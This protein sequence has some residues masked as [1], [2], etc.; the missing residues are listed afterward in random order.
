MKLPDAIYAHVWNPE[1]LHKSAQLE[2]L[3]GD[4][5]FI[6]GRS[7]ADD[8]G[9]KLA[10]WGDMRDGVPYY[11]LWFFPTPQEAGKLQLIPQQYPDGPDS[12]FID[13]CIPRRLIDGTVCSAVQGIPT[14]DLVPALAPF[15][16]KFAAIWWGFDFQRYLRSR[17]LQEA[18]TCVEFADFVRFA[19]QPT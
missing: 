18:T 2:A 5:L 9:Y 10:H 3:A 19:Q 1:F 15:A 17:D 14:L 8:S 4:E 13:N 16:E 7:H 11:W 12:D 6:P